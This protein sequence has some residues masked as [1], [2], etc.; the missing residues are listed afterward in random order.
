MKRSSVWILV[1][2]G[3]PSRPTEPPPDQR[4]TVVQS[5]Q[6]V[7]LAVIG[8]F[9][10]AGEAEADVAALV[11]SWT[12]DFVVTTG[13]NNYPDGAAET[14]DANIGQYYHDYIAP[15]SGSYGAGAKHNRFFPALGNHDWRASDLKPHSDYFALPGNERYYAVSWGP[16]DVF[17]VDSDAHEPD[18]VDAASKQAQ[19]L[20]AEL[21]AADGPW[22]L[23][24][25]HHP[26]FSSGD[27]GSEEALQWPYHEW[28]ATAV[29]AGHDHHYER[30]EIDGQLYLV[31]GLGGYPKRYEIHAPLPGSAVRFNEDWGAMRIYADLQGI[32]FEFVARSGKVVDSFERKREG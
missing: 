16:V 32:R 17:V 19:W 26:P 25:M 27:H 10:A 30:L 28:G 14:I 21:A 13:D 29:I 31:N 2:A 18:G 4:V 9:G 24:F 6:S 23:V 11:H 20:K 12:P 3:C 8:D 5:A 15:Y 7:Q 22:K 1:L